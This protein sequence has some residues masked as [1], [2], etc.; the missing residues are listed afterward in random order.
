M[1]PVTSMV[2]QQRTRTICN[3][4]LIDRNPNL[5]DRNLLTLGKNLKG[6]SDCK[7]AKFYKFI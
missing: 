5:I 6:Q 2:T 3:P 1:A 4:N 7:D